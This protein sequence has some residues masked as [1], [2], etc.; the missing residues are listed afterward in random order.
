MQPG[1]CN[2]VA[3]SDLKDERALI[4]KSQVLIPNIGSHAFLDPLPKSRKD[5]DKIQT[6]FPS[7]HKYTPK[8]F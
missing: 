8:G 5:N 6:T 3:E 2:F 4:W 1:N 7:Y